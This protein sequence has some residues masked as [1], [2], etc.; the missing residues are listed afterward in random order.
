MH[1]NYHDLKVRSGP[2]LEK[3]SWYSVDSLYAPSVGAV[4]AGV[5]AGTKCIAIYASCLHGP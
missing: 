5:L 4:R 3:D 2:M 1:L